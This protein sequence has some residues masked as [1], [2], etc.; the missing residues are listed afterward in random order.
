[1][2]FNIKNR[3][4]IKKGQKNEKMLFEDKLSDK[5]LTESEKSIELSHEFLLHI[6]QNQ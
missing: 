5:Q 2:L 4:N 6:I 3:K 1:M